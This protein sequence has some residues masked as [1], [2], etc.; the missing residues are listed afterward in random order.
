ML[1]C[2]CYHSREI[3]ATAAAETSSSTDRRFLIK[4]ATKTVVTYLK[5]S[6]DKTRKV[7]DLPSCSAGGRQADIYMSRCIQLIVPCTLQVSCAV[8]G[9]WVESTIQTKDGKQSRPDLTEDWSHSVKIQ[10]RA[11]WPIYHITKAKFHRVVFTAA[12]ALDARHIL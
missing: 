12:R 10:N 6:A 11:P 2:C 4:M 1:C 5:K 9:V 3:T 8:C 7:R